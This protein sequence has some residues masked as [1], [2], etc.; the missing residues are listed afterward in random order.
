MGKTAVPRFE[1]GR[2]SPVEWRAGTVTEIL[3]M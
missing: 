3:E 2:L 1:V